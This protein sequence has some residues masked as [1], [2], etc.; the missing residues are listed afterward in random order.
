MR[1][2]ICSSTIVKEEKPP[3]PPDKPWKPRS[4][5][6]LYLPSRQASHSRQARIGSTTTRS[7][8]L[9][10][11]TPAPTSTTSPENSWPITI[12]AMSWLILC[13]LS[14]G[15]KMGPA[16]YSCRSL[17][18][19]PVHATLIL[20]LPADTC[21]SSMSS[22]RISCALYQRAA[23]IIF[24]LRVEQEN[25]SIAAVSGRCRNSGRHSAKSV[26]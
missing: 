19:I 6:R 1:C 25:L 21:G 20:T 12:G 3:P 18:Q 15:T 5:H 4:P 26:P 7:P 13:G 9:N 8:A 17:P 10:L 23:F 24:P 22:M 16:R 14:T 2:T 11:L